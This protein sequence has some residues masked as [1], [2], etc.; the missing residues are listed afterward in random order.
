[1][2]NSNSLVGASMG[3]FFHSGGGG[4]GW[5]GGLNDYKKTFINLLPQR[6]VFF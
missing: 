3:A 1:M 2:V 4:G 5:G 6:E